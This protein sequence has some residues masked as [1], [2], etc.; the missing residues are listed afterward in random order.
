MFHFE[1][2]IP[3]FLEFRAMSEPVSIS[4]PV[5]VL[6]DLNEYG[7]RLLTSSGDVVYRQP[8]TTPLPDLRMP[9]SNRSIAA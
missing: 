4:V 6:R 9:R 3:V 7:E 8:A 2:H 1:T 5:Y